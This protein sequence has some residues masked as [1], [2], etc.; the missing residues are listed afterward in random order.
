MLVLN[1]ALSRIASLLLPEEK[2]AHSKFCIPIL[3]NEKSTCNIPQESLRARLLIK[4]KLI[5]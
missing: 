1:V 5:T 3:I 2:I 4:T